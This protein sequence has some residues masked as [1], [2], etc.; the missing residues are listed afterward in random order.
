MANNATIYRGTARTFQAVI[1][2]SDDSDTMYL[3]VGN[4][5]GTEGDLVLPLTFTAENGPNGEDVWEGTL[6]AEMT[7]AFAVGSYRAVVWKTNVDAEDLPVSNGR[8][9]IADSPRA[10]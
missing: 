10:A 3:V 6:T 2:G 9:V 8:I 5:D 7:D 1:D 4:T